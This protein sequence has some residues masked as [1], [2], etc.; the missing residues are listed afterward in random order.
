MNTELLLN[1]IEKDIF[2]RQDMY[3]AAIKERD[4]F[5]ETD[6]RNLIETLQKDGLIIRISHNH[7]VRNDS[8]K[9]KQIYKPIYSDEA[10]EIIADIK[11]QYP[12]L[13]FQVWELAWFNEF[14]VHLIAH[15]KIFVDVENDGCEFV[16]SSLSEKYHGKMLLRP[17]AKELQYYFQGEGIIVERMISE[18][19]NTKGM[20]YETPIE[21]LIVEMFANKSLMSMISK[22]DYPYALENMFEKYS[23]DQVK[24][25][26]YARRRNREKEL[27]SYIN[28][29]TKIKLIRKA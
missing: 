29:H 14:L 1:S 15:N 12:Y 19:P 8:S 5:K 24:M 10:R 2:S 23:I 3:E 7:Y 28:E 17:S 25:L 13:S 9:I 11:E 27:V 20:P 22:G 6:M 4:G 26:R 16:Y 21:K 18:S